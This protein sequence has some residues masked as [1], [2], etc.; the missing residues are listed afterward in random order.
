MTKNIQSLDDNMAANKIQ[1]ADKIKWLQP[2]EAPLRLSGFQ[3]FTEDRVYRRLPLRTKPM[4]EKINDNLNMLC[5]NTSG[6]QIAFKTNSTRI[7]L[8]VELQMPHHMVNMP[9]TG[10][11]G[12][13]CYLGQK[14]ERLKFFGVTK[15]DIKESNYECELVSGLDGNRIRDV[16]LNFPLY[17]GVKDV[18]IGVDEDAVLEVP[19]PFSSPGK[20]VFYGTSI[21][22]GGCASR[23]GMAYTNILSRWFNRE[24]VNLGFSANGLGEYE[25]A[26]IIAE[27]RNPGIIVLDY[28]ANSDMNGRLEASLE[29]FIGI[30]RE[31]HLFTPILLLSRIPYLADYRDSKLLERRN[32]LREFQRNT[33]IK[34]IENGDKNI[35]FHNGNE[36]YDA[37][38]D[39]Y[40]VDFI[41]P[42]DLGFWK[43][44]EGLYPVIEKILYK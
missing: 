44:A 8:R 26:D 18:Q 30:I 39:E 38:F 35:Y 13:D 22:Q 17:D 27:I 24:C 5:E 36:L 21:T 37:Y 28:E 7:F 43:M 16:L 40:T 10:Q 11:S 25:M 31:K 20:M 3:Y 1:M 6:G 4:F 9:A 42:S 41:H 12:F 23:P 2:Y 14:G 32:E 33:V 29:G 15:F 19:A 34:F